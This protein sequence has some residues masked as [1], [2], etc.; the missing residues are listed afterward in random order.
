MKRNLLLVF[1]FGVLLAGCSAYK[2][3]KVYQINND[4]I[5]DKPI[6]QVWEKFIEYFTLS[7]TPIKNMDKNLGFISTET[8]LSVNDYSGYSDCGTAGNMVLAKQEITNPKGHFN[9]MIKENP[10]GGTRVV[11]KTFFTATSVVYNYMSKSESSWGLECNS[12]GKLEERLF[13]YLLE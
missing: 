3:P 4:R 5:I 12:T 7:G 11:I 2:P 9:I 6:E 10:G 1:L 13:R 8:N